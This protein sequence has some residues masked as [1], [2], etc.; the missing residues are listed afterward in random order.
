MFIE[1]KYIDL[2]L[3]IKDYRAFIE[4]RTGS[5]VLPFLYISTSIIQTTPTYAL[6]MLFYQVLLFYRLN[7]IMKKKTIFLYIILWI[8]FSL[9]K[10]SL[11]SFSYFITHI[12]MI[13]S[14]KTSQ[15]IVFLLF[16]EFLNL[17]RIYCIW[18]D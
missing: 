12:K 7:Y 10:W 8:F 3:P 4:N 17:E 15:L 1:S 13:K 18:F 6:N 16:S 2:S 9:I 14:D 5:W 11:Y